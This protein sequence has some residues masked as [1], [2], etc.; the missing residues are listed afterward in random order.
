MLHLDFSGW[1]GL[2]NIFL[3]LTRKESQYIHHRHLFVLLSNGWIVTEVQITFL[4]NRLM[5]AS[6][7][8]KNWAWGAIY[9]GLEYNLFIPTLCI[10]VVLKYL[11]CLYK[12]N[13]GINIIVLLTDYLR[14]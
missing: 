6:V 11:C 5:S 3:Y 4:Y 1:S 10:R 9:S 2:T 8:L 13:I 7:F 12:I 14:I